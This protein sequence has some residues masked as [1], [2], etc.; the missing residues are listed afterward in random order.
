MRM[1]LNLLQSIRRVCSLL[2][3]GISLKTQR[4]VAAAGGTIILH[5]L[6][7]Y[8]KW[9]GVDAEKLTHQSGARIILRTEDAPEER[10]VCV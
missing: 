2:L 6:L 5:T 4:T 8:D 3:T 1:K 9:R 7:L 10:N